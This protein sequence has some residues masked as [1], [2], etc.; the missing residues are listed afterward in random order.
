MGL[1]ARAP[2][3]CGRLVQ[4]LLDAAQSLLQ[5]SDTATAQE[6]LLCESSKIIHFVMPRSNV[7]ATHLR[8][9]ESIT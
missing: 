3:E 5:G 4:Q 8:D 2:R 1:Q 9:L 6:F 7:H